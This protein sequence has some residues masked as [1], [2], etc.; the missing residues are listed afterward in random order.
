M[1]PD[2]RSLLTVR[3]AHLATWLRLNQVE[4]IGVERD[5]RTA[6]LRYQWYYERTPAV[7]QLF[8]IWRKTLNEFMH[9]TSVPGGA[10]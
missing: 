5:P 9:Q 3:S 2:P 8:S 1:A 6:E 7:E 4:P 10:R